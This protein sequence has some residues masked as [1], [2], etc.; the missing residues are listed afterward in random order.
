MGAG[1][2]R[3]GDGGF[4]SAGCLISGLV[5]APL[6]PG[7]RGAGGEG[8]GGCGRTCS[9]KLPPLPNPSP[10]GV[11]G[12]EPGW[13]ARL[14]LRFEAREVLGSSRT[15]MT[16]RNHFGPLRIL[17][18]LYPE[19][20]DI[21]HGVIVHPPGGIVAGD[22]LAIDICVDENA[23]ALITTPGMQKW[24]RSSGKQASADTQLRVADG[25][26]LEWMP[27]ETMVF[28]GA[29]AEQV[30]DITLA[31][32]ARLFGWEMLCLGRTTRGE[33]FTTGEFRQRIRLVHRG[34]ET[35]QGAPMWRESMILRGDDPLM[36]SALGMRGLPVIATAWIVFPP[37]AQDSA[38]LLGEI[39]VVL[40]DAPLAAASSPEPGLIVMKAIGDSPET[41]RN[42]LIAVWS[43]IRMQVIGRKPELPRIWST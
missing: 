33:R 19:G 29:W 7:G 32:G 27:Q 38:T 25:A 13:S 39:R 31:P 1:G 28:D 12:L 4:E 43:K 30:L 40:N 10:T 9:S 18:P 41:V 24:Y 6:A 26:S 22:S 20:H 36:T 8:E 21:C 23:N 34:E 11:E 14:N 35:G 42:L 17:K 5:D 37:E 3:G 15:V 16:E 2:G